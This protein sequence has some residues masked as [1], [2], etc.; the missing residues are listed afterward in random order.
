MLHSQRVSA[1][2]CVPVELL[3]S[4]T[5]GLLDGEAPIVREAVGDTVTVE[6][7]LTVVEGVKE[8]VPVPEPEGVAEE[9]GVGD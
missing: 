5:L 7:P 3:E 8:A 9:V 4:D 1:W 2:V 6:L